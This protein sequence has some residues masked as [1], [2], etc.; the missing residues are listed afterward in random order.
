VQKGG[1]QAVPSD[2]S[3]GVVSGVV[4]N[5]TKKGMMYNSP[6]K[7]KPGDQFTAK[8]NYSEEGYAPSGSTP[9]EVH[10]QVRWCGKEPECDEF[11]TGCEILKSKHTDKELLREFVQRFSRSLPA[12]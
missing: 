11:S 8:L 12:T 4:K 1:R 10:M 3:G 7:H 9:L 2:S 5:F 6:H